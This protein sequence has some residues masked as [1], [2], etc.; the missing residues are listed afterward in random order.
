MFL[1][2]VLIRHLGPVTLLLHLLGLKDGYQLW[3]VYGGLWED[4]MFSRVPF[5]P[6]HC[7]PPILRTWQKGMLCA[8]QGL[9]EYIQGSSRHSLP[10]PGPEL[11][12]RLTFFFFFLHSKHAN[13]LSL[14]EVSCLPTDIS[15]VCLLV[16]FFQGDQ[17]PLRLKWNT[18]ANRL[19][20]WGL[21]F[22]ML[23]ADKTFLTLASTGTRQREVN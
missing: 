13:V 22:D 19:K 17:R 8:L 5:L 3:E 23:G 11:L 2:W 12:K 18:E 21:L 15:F 14:L 20:I 1:V 16:F 6:F 9:E 7:C 4:M 10:L